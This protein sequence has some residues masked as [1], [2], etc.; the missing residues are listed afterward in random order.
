[1]RQAR[2]LSKQRQFPQRIDTNYTFYN[3]KMCNNHT[4]YNEK[5]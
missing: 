3:E 5:V 4:F 2:R 1:M